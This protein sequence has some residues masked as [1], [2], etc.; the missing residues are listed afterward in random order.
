MLHAS[1]AILQLGGNNL[2]RLACRP[3][4]LAKDIINLARQLVLEDSNDA[5]EQYS[6]RPNIQISGI[7]D[8]YVETLLYYDWPMLTH[9]VSYY[10]GYFGWWLNLHTNFT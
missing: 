2:T 8:E 5:I 6:R 1:K 9:I 7:A 4:Q 3:D 10:R